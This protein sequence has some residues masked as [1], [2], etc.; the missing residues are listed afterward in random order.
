MELTLR[1][2]TEKE[3]QQICSYIRDFELD[4]R[5]LQLQQFVAAFRN[6]ELVG[7]GRLREHSDCTELCSLGVITPLRRK[8]IGKAI[9]KELVKRAGTK[10][11]LVC[12]IPDF[13]TPFD[14]KITSTYPFAIGDKL[15]YC[16]EQLV[17]RE[18]YVAME[19]NK[20]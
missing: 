14:F 3:F 16:T 7:F 17:V 2:P 18:A 11:Y 13:F 8:G 9:V 19:L 6:N 5:D 4:D 20:I 12:I 1:N 10:L 15:N